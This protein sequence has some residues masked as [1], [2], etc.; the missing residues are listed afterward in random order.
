MQILKDHIKTE[1]I[2]AASINDTLGKT[3]SKLKSSHDAAFVFNE[4]KKF[5][6]L[7]NPY[8][9][10]IKSSSHD[11]NTKNKNA[12]F[13][14]PHIGIKD[15]FDK[16]AKLMIESKIHY[17]PV[18]DNDN[19]FQGIITARRILRLL[20]ENL[21]KNL[22]ISAIKHTQ[23]GK[24][25]TISINDPVSKAL[26][27]FKEFKTSKIVAVDKDG[28]LRGI[29]S[30]YDLIPYLVAP[31]QR[32]EGIGRGN[33]EH[34]HDTPIKNFVKTT[35]LRVKSTETVI[36]ILSEI[37]DKEIGS[38]VIIDEKQFPLGIVTTKDL[39]DLLIFKD[40]NQPIKISKRKLDKIHK[41]VFDD[42]I[43][44]VKD[45]I[46]KNRSIKGCEIHYKSEK[47]GHLHKIQLHLNFE[48]KETIVIDREEHDFS[49]L[50]QDVKEVLRNIEVKMS[51]DE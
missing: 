7:I 8:Y 35:V 18:F 32:Q 50:L 1:G 11:G 36:K 47:D 12:L 34:L 51:Q 5:M 48:V 6:G 16:V 44:F 45:F 25:I 43:F 30:H 3:L 14:P 49:R 31:P 33:K 23:K 26:T 27:L 17:L 13:H 29:L 2:I 42:F 24:V 46:K 19:K 20:K 10:I 9:A 28:K 39:L 37:L 38:M 4:E 41:I 40:G 22:T 15:G 21:N